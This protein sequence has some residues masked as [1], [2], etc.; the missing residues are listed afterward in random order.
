VGV[1][2]SNS[3][4]ELRLGPQGVVACRMVWGSLIE[5]KGREERGCGLSHGLGELGRRGSGDDGEVMIW[6]AVRRHVKVSVMSV[7][8]LLLKS[9]WS[10]L[11]KGERNKC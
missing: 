5:G 10:L 7:M 9:S 2:D 8:E 6:W 1:L 3:D 4:A 11:W